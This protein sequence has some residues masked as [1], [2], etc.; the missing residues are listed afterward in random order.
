MTSV[1]PTA[2]YMVREQMSVF[3]CCSG[4]VYVVFT[5]ELI[6][7][8]PGV[9]APIR[10]RYRWFGV[11]CAPGRGLDQSWR[12]WTISASSAGVPSKVSASVMAVASCPWVRPMLAMTCRRPLP[13][14]RPVL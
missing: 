1:D 8:V 14:R 3:A 9:V 7:T 10:A 12:S 2:V 13:S 4:T 5:A 11:A 6:T